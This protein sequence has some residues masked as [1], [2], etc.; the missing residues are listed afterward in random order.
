MKPFSTVACLLLGLIAV[1][2][3]AR[4]LLGWEISVNGMAVP[5]WPSAVATLLFGAVSV[6]A[7][8]ERSR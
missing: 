6:L 8:R 2:Q 3:L 4:L 5:L 7:W 1:L